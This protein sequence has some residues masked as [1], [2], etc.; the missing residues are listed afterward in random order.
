MSM[1][2]VGRP[3]GEVSKDWPANGTLDVSEIT[4]PSGTRCD[5]EVRVITTAG[6]PEI[7][8][9]KKSSDPVTGVR[10]EEKTPDPEPGPT[11]DNGETQSSIDTNA[12]AISLRTGLAGKQAR[13]ISFTVK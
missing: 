12:S 5:W 6:E 11:P 9:T 4:S 8:A 7:N 2:V 13:G 1:A 10:Y 3:T